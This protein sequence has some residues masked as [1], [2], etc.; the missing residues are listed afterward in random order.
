MISGAISL[1][2]GRSLIKAEELYEQIRKRKQSQC[3]N[4]AKNTGFTL[5]QCEMVWFYLFIQEHTLHGG[6]MRFDSDLPIAQSWLRLSEKNG[7]NILPHDILLLQH[8]LCEIS[9][10]LNNGLSQEQAHSVAE[11]QFNY[12]AACMQYYIQ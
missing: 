7:R 10:Q 3:R 9:L 5:M 4:I 12:H 8:E 6:T 11:Q 1:S 2:D